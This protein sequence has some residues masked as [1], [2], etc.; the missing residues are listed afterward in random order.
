MIPFLGAKNKPSAIHDRQSHLLS[1]REYCYH[2]KTKSVQGVGSPN[3]Y[4]SHAPKAGSQV[5]LTGL[6]V[7]GKSET[8]TLLM[9]QLKIKKQE[10]A[11]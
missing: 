10:I 3:C 6:K 4:T 9:Y 7:I 5:L 2:L 1:C 8:A 11:P